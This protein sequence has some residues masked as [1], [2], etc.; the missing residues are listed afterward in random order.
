MDDTGENL[1]NCGFFNHF[2][3]DSEATKR[4]WI[5]FFCENTGRLL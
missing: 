1:V 5:Q 4:G 2:K 3:G